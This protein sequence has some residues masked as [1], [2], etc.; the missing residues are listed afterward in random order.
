MLNQSDGV[1]PLPTA[2]EIN[3]ADVLQALGDARVAL[4]KLR[5][6]VKHLP[7]PDIL[8][9]TL[10][11]QEA[12]AS[13][14]IENI[15][16]E[17]DEAFQA[18]SLPEAVSPE[19]KEVVRYRDAM[20][21]GYN[22]LLR[23]NG[24][25]ENM[26][27]DM[28][29]ILLKREDGYRTTPGTK[30]RNQQTGQ[31]VY[32]P[33]QDPQEI[34]R[35]MR[36]LEA[37]INQEGEDWIDGMGDIDGIHPLIRMALIHHRFESIHPFPDGNGRVGRILNVLY[38]THAGLLDKP[39]LYLS[40]AINTNKPEYY[41]LLQTVRTEGAWEA[42]VVYMLEMVTETAIFT[43]ILILQIQTLM[44]QT[45]NRMLRELPKILSENLIN[46]LFRHPYTRI[47]LL[48]RDI[49]R[50]AQTARRYLLQL[51]EKGIVREVRRGRSNYYINDPL[52]ELLKRRL[53]GIC[54]ITRS[55]NSG[56]NYSPA[57]MYSAK[58]SDKSQRKGRTKVSEIKLFV[59][60]SMTVQEIPGKT[61]N[62]EKDIQT[63]FENHLDTLLDIRFVCRRVFRRGRAH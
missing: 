25:S 30:L 18:A 17:Q 41:R 43:K 54:E 8:I 9:E 36:E 28:F 53:R 40:R 22:D 7:N 15:V 4:G 60:T 6:E 48:A 20:W 44:L 38:M 26:L 31:I 10:F 45:E 2:E 52:V 14:E 32:E 16:T 57:L 51:A 47:E 1:A 62:F 27:I 46:N 12:W 39:I 23:F 59:A 33:P 11:L 13:S 61:A 5:Y 24:I 55:L 50:D 29:R 21:H 35:L 34:V 56:V 42:W 37:F 63:L 49:S 19:A 58:Y 3:T